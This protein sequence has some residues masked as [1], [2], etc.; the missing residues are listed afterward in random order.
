MNVKVL[1][2]PEEKALGLQGLPRIP[3]DTIYVFVGPPVGGYFHSRNVPEP[4]DLAFLSSDRRVICRGFLT[5]PNDT[6]AVPVGAAYAI[7][8]KFGVL[9]QFIVLGKFTLKFSDA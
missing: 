3:D 9:D 8:T 6:A 2:T 5:P 1:L 7:E 4:F